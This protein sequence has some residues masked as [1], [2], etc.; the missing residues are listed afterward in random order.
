MFMIL[1]INHIIACDLPLQLWAKIE[2]RGSWYG[3]G[4]WE[5]EGKSWL[6]KM[7]ISQAS[8]AESYAASMHWALTCRGLDPA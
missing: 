7:E 8:F 3:I 6:V 1:L 4:T 5:L 2:C